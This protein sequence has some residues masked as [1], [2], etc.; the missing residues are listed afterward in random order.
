MHGRACNGV[1][2]ERQHAKAYPS[3]SFQ[4]AANQGTMGVR[5]GCPETGVTDEESFSARSDAG[6]RC[7]ECRRLAVGAVIG[8]P[9]GF[10]GPRSS[11]ALGKLSELQKGGM[12]VPE[13]ATGA[14]AVR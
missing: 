1:I 2:I 4:P 10:G 7:A 11:E 5:S 13:L 12:P 6:A 14:F 9:C 8:G 3:G